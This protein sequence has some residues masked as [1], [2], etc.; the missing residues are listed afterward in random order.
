MHGNHLCSIKIDFR[1][2]YERTISSHGA[3]YQITPNDVQFIFLILFLCNYIKRLRL[4]CWMMVQFPTL[5][6]IIKIKLWVNSLFILKIACLLWQCHVS[7][8]KFM[9]DT[10]FKLEKSL[11]LF[12][13]I[14]Q[15][16]CFFFVRTVTLWMEAH[17]KNKSW[18]S[19]ERMRCSGSK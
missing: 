10:S 8:W 7:P 5:F 19:V 17:F 6:L 16:T 3:I 15:L 13:A 1:E 18:D 2:S 12:A 14:T 11:R 4:L 9:T